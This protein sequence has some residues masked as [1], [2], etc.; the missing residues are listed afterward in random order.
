MP[1]ALTWRAACSSACASSSDGFSSRGGPLVRP[2]FFFGRI[3]VPFSSRRGKMQRMNR[4]TFIGTSL[5][6][7]LSAAAKPSWA[8]ARLNPGFAKAIPENPTH[9]I[10]RIGLQLYTVRAAMKTDFGGTIAKVAAT[11]YKEE[12]GRASCRERVEDTE[13]AVSL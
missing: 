2:P 8:A 3:A 6:A 5:A 7:T 1:A 11:G 10:A 4:R 9:K 12:I 13:V